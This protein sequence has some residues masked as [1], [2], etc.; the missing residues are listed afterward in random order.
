ML[1]RMKK[2]R[3]IKLIIVHALTFAFLLAG[4]C[5]EVLTVRPFGY[6]VHYALLLAG[7]NPLVSAYYLAACVIAEP[8]LLSFA[9]A[10]GTAIA[11]AAAGFILSACRRIKRKRMWRGIIHTLLQLPLCALLT[12]FTGGTV[13]A[14]LLTAAIGTACGAVMSFAVPLIAGKDLLS[15]TSFESAGAGVL[16][17]VL[18]S[19]LGGVN[20][21]GYPVAYTV[22]AFTV[23]L[24]CKCRSAETGLIA[25]I[26]AAFGVALAERDP[27]S[28]A[29]LVLA[30]V[31]CRAF[32]AGARPLPA[33]ALM[34]GWA[35]GAYFFA[36]SPPDA[37]YPAAIAAGC[38]L[39][40]LL[41]GRALRALS[42]YFRSAGRLTDIAAAAGMGR[43]LPERLVRASEALGEMS[44]LMSSGGGREYAADCV[45][46]ALAGICAACPR[47]DTCDMSG[48][49]RSLSYDYASGGSALKSAVLGEPCISGGKLL[50]LAGEVMR[51]VR[52]RAETA[53]TEKR[54]AESYAR[55]LESLRKLVG[56]MAEELTEDY[57]FDA[58]LSEK[59]RRDLPEA[60]MACGGCLVTAKRR[61]IVLVPRS[62]SVDA[63]ERAIGRVIG[64]VRIER[65]GD[66]TPLW[67]AAAFAPAPELDVVYACASRPKDG[68]PVSGDGYSVTGFGARALVSLCD[69]SGSGRPASR[70]SRAALSIIED[71]YKAGFDAAEG[72]DSVNSF[73]S[74]RP[75][76]EF[77]A[78][79]VLGIDL[80]TGETDIIKAG[81]PPT[82]VMRGETV[83]VIG[84]SSLPVGALDNASY[85]LARRRLEAGDCI[86]MVTDGV[87][88]VL[89]DLP[90]AAS[91]A[92]GPNVRRMAE[93]ILAAACGQ[94][95]RDDMSVL[96]VRLVRSSEKTDA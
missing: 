24:A 69:G 18:F 46:D 40:L 32:S 53:E 58:K 27:Y 31:M 39:F 68:N 10:G 6:G 57:R 44:A 28:A 29:A 25:G 78:M 71:Q 15:P 88:D 55:R 76:E 5:A 51:E 22:F 52:G 59:L 36:S 91:A 13:L 84:G 4:A 82:L 11:G 47:H 43:L 75:G 64:G 35:A 83:T 17:T 54:N 61:G 8:A 79:D 33:A 65:I 3:I 34:L 41:P 63:A 89:K 70:L 45:G 60:G 23:P 26:L 96:V 67:Q 12:Y 21:F 38:V 50:R 19:G 95:C 77:G 14:S 20:V 62:E 80:V 92:F 42:V 94:G 73:L 48:N 72:V 56:R 49:I 9:R 87:S 74:S 7:C 93:S 30:A 1:R 85:S 37:M 66:V 90:A 2:R 86:V 81:T 16:C